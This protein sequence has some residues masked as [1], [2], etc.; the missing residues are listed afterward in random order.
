[1]D[2]DPAVDEW[3]TLGRMGKEHPHAISSKDH[4][5]THQTN[6]ATKKILTKKP[7]LSETR[8]FYSSCYW[9]C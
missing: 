7:K 2:R 6:M 5:D 9:H 8:E 3:R 4:Q 1:M